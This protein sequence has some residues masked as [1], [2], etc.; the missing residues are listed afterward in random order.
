MASTIATNTTKRNS[1]RACAARFVSSGDRA[2]TS[3]RIE[4][5][6]NRSPVR[7][8]APAPATVAKVA[9]SCTGP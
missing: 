1:N 8:A 2:I 5:A 9:Q 3:I 7:L 4:T 6:T